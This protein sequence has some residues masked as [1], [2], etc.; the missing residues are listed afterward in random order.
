MAK[1]KLSESNFT[2]VPEGVTVF[3]I[4]EVDESKYD[5]FGKINIKMTTDK[6]ISHVERFSFIKANGDSNEGAIKAFSFMAR[7]ALNN[8]NLDEIEASDLVGCYLKAEVKHETREGTG[9]YA[10]KIYTDV[11]LNN[12][13]V[14]NG[15]EGGDADTNEDDDLDNFLEN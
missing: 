14:A 12:Y 7:K 4:T 6:G 9:E 13:E 2:I 10:G 8:Q 11:R 1:I 3:K 15:F 5:D